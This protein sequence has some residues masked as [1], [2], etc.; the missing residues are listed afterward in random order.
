MSDK[1]ESHSKAK[2]RKKSPAKE[3]IIPPSSKA[4]FPRSSAGATSGC[5]PVSIPI[6]VD[7]GGEITMLDPWRRDSVNLTRLDTDTKPVDWES[8]IARMVETALARALQPEP[9]AFAPALQP[10]KQLAPPAR[11][12]GPGPSHLTNDAYDTTQAPRL[13]FHVSSARAAQDPA[14]R[15]SH[16][17]HSPLPSA[18]SPLPGRSRRR[19]RAVVYERQDRRQERQSDGR[20]ITVGRSRTVSLALPPASTDTVMSTSLPAVGHVMSTDDGLTANDSR[21]LR[22]KLPPPPTRLLGDRDV[23]RLIE[24]SPTQSLCSDEPEPEPHPFAEV[25]GKK[26][27]PL[28]GLKSPLSRQPSADAPSVRQKALW[29]QSQGGSEV[30]AVKTFR[31]GAMYTGSSSGKSLLY[32]TFRHK[33]SFK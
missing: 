8:R 22:M 13:S 19:D 15:R 3:K 30:R 32:V 16:G 31:I 10:G 23:K 12:P 4:E 6:T 7:T 1:N 11:Q 25:P 18:S 20:T 17:G 28:A 5:G 2:E 27:C 24:F 26:D 9:P 29:T 33:R 14:R 21:Q